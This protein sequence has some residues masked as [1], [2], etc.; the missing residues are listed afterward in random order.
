MKRL[1]I[2]IS[3][4]IIFSNVYAQDKIILNNNDTILCKIIEDKILSI[5]YK[6]YN[7]DDTTT[8]SISHEKFSGYV[9]GSKS[10]STFSDK[11]NEKANFVILEKKAKIT[12]TTNQIILTRYMKIQKDKISYMQKTGS[13]SN[14]ELNK[15]S[16]VCLKKGNWAVEMGF[17]MLGLGLLT[18]TIDPSDNMSKGANYAAGT[19]WGVGGALVGL[20][21]PKY[22]KVIYFEGQWKD[23]SYKVD[24]TKENI[25]PN[26]ANDKIEIEGL[27]VG[28]I[29]IINLQGQVIKNIN[30]TRE[31]TTIN[32]SKLTGGVYTMRIKTND[33]IIVKKLVKQ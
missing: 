27:Q 24:W 28:Q 11:V 19:A 6:L 20:L 10:K 9:E 21:I 12:T 22:K 32:I 33:G 2:F 1:I 26:P 31:R 30:L 25:Y 13:M 29:E 15:I 17:I 16:N 4:C 7:S 8:Y 23:N 14:I 18:A 3:I 5:T